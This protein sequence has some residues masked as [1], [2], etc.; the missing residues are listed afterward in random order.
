[1]IILIVIILLVLMQ[2]SGKE[3][4]GLKDAL[5]KE[6]QDYPPPPDFDQKEYE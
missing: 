3:Q 2:N 5:P 6:S 4:P 1:V